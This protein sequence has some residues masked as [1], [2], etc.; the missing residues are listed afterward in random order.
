ME[1]RPRIAIVGSANLDLTMQVP[2]LP[3][4]GETV[5]GGCFA[6]HYGGK[7]ANQAVAA[8]RA[9]AR[10]VWIGCVGN[11]PLTKEMLDHFKREDLCLGHVRVQE[12]K[13]TGTALVMYD[14]AG[15]NYLAVD[16]GA[17]NFLTVEQVDAARETLARSDW[18][19][20]QMEVPTAINQLVIAM[21]AQSG[22][23]VLLNYAPAHDLS[24]SGQ[25]MS[26]GLVV[27][28]SEA[29]ALLGQPINA[30]DEAGCREAGAAL[31]ERGHS[32][33]V[34]TLGSQG[35]VVADGGGL[36]HHPACPTVA[37]DTTA[38]G[39]TFCGYLATALAQGYALDEAVR[40]ATQAAA[41]CVSRAG[42][43][44]SIPTRMQVEKAMAPGGGRA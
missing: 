42:A 5:V 10:A 16:S 40:W 24:L 17:N 33:V 28:E 23:P 21:A 29:A 7:G 14:Q 44:D 11:D 41:L 27:N 36:R 26:G 13:P 4:C 32:F 8:A 20:L 2:H 30:R 6:R 39:D 19:L 25:P 38:A 37:V 1:V 31:L 9:G 15:L 43:Q 22:V 12:E 34:L 18:I 3:A 35:S